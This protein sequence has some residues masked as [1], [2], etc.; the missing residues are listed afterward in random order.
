MTTLNKS[1]G[2]T[3][4]ATIAKRWAVSRK[5]VQRLFRDEPGVLKLGASRYRLRIPTELL[6]RK[7]RE[8]AA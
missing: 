8:L 6:K 3:T 4:V 7:E 5:T 2:Y 1:T